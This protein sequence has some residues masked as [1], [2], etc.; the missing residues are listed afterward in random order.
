MQH[1][2]AG[3]GCESKRATTNKRQE[4]S[5]GLSMGKDEVRTGAAV[6][7]YP[8]EV[9]HQSGGDGTRSSQG[10]RLGRAPR[11]SGHSDQGRGQ[12]SLEA[13]I[14]LAVARD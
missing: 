1:M 3:K 2:V 9:H 14:H 10:F 6:G 13:G 5:M 4:L 11:G 7:Q 8:G 12:S